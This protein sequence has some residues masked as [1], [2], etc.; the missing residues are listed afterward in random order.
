MDGAPIDVVREIY[1]R[2]IF[3]EDPFDLMAEDIVWEVPMFDQAEPFI[4]HYGR[5]DFF[6]R[7]LGTWD[8]YRIDLEKT[9]EAP[10]GRI[11]TFFAERARGRGSGVEVETRAAGTWTVDAGKVV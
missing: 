9:M 3:D 5:A 1:R 7:W 6:R 10:D 2:F 4:G 8:H 11:V